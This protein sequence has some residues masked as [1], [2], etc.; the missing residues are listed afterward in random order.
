MK[1]NLSNKRREVGAK[2]IR[3]VCNLIDRFI[4]REA[5]RIFLTTHFGYRRTTVEPPTAPELPDVSRENCGSRRR[6]RVRRS[7][8]KQEER[9]KGEKAREEAVG[10]PEQDA[11]RSLLAALPGGLYKTTTASPESPRR[12]RRISS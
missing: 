4:E 3:A 11:V 2:H 5:S 10:R 8:D 9:C 6:A 1:K 7:G 12:K